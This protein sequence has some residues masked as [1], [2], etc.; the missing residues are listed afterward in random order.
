MAIKLTEKQ[1]SGYNLNLGF[2]IFLSIKFKSSILAFAKNI[3]IINLFNLSFNLFKHTIYGFC[4]ISILSVEKAISQTQQKSPSRKS[5]DWWCCT[6]HWLDDLL[7]FRANS[8]LFWLSCAILKYKYYDTCCWCF[9]NFNSNIFRA[10]SATCNS[11]W[12]A[13]FICQ[14]FHPNKLRHFN[15]S[16]PM[17]RNKHYHIFLS[18]FWIEF[19]YTACIIKA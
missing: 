16:P 7:H 12:S 17:L 18:T 3:K 4:L 2:Q 1:K 14:Q 6:Y 19:F 15:T 11:A 5:W 9:E 13:C 8:V 10:R